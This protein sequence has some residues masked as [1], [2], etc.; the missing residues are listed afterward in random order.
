M[1]LEYRDTYEKSTSFRIDVNPEVL[2]GYLMRHQKGGG[3]DLCWANHAFRMNA[4]VESGDYQCEC[5]QW[6]HIGVAI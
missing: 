3:E 6:E 2:H 1:Y 5:Q 4:G